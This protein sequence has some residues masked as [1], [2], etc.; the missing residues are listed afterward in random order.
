M[1]ILYFVLGFTRS[2]V[3]FNQRFANLLQNRGNHSISIANIVH[4]SDSWNFDYGNN[5]E[6]VDIVNEHRYE[7]GAKVKYLPFLLF[8]NF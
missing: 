6:T 4:T 1:R 7:L 8:I 5:I 2:I 3:L